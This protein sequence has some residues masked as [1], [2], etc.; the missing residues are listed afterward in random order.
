MLKQ[1][2]NEAKVT[3]MYKILNNFVFVDH[4]LEFNTNQ[5]WV[6]PFKLTLEQTYI[7]TLNHY[8]VERFASYSCYL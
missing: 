7:M 6:H 4:D 5:T 8:F 2:R 3:M 1:Q